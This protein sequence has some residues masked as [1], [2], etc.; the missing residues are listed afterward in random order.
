MQLFFPALNI[1]RQDGPILFHVLF[2]DCSGDD[3]Q[4]LHVL[5]NAAPAGQAFFL[6]L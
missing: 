2:Y 3:P 6:K 4:N 1:G 5:Q